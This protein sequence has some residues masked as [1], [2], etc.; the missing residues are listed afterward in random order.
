M[1]LIFLSKHWK[2][3]GDSKNGENMQQ[4]IAG[5]LDNLAELGNRKF[6]LLIREYF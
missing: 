6:S 5:F 4:K 3:N 2:F 1:R